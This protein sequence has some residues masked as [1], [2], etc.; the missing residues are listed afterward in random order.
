MDEKLIIPQKKY[1][2]ETSVV[3]ARLPNDLIRDLNEVTQKT[4][5]NRNELIQICLEFALQRIE[6]ESSEK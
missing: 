1:T 6:I 2:E 3:S 4:G 5:H